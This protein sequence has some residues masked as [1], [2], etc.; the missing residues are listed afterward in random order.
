MSDILAQFERRQSVGDEAHGSQPT[1]NRQQDVVRSSRPVVVPKPE[2]P[3][4]GQSNIGRSLVSIFGQQRPQQN[5][6]GQSTFYERPRP[7]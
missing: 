5:S 2:V 7:R 4:W 3:R 1:N 6:Q